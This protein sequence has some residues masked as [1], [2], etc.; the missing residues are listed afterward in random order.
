MKISELLLAVAAC[1]ALSMSVFAQ[2]PTTVNID[3]FFAILDANKDG[4]IGRGE[5]KEGP[6]DKSA[7]P[8]FRFGWIFCRFL[9]GPV[10]GRNRIPQ[11]PVAIE[12][13]ARLK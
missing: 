1:F 5:W 3:P 13:K 4:F 6:P 8:L 12:V 11:G 10:I 7:D 2:S 9:Q